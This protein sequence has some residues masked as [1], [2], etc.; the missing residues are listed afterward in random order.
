MTLQI[1]PLEWE[2][3]PELA[4]IH[5]QAFPKSRST[6]LGTLYVRKMFKWFIK[7]QPSLGY[8]AKQDNRIVGYVVGAIGGYGRKLFRFTLFEILIGLVIH[9]RLWTR[10]S[11]Y[12]LWTSYIKGLLPNQRNKKTDSDSNQGQPTSAALAGIGVHPEKRGLGVGKALVQEFEIAAKNLGTEKLTLSVSADNLQARRL[13]E[14]CGW[15]Q[16]NEDLK[17][18]SVHYSKRVVNVNDP[19]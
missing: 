12:S 11:T 17:T 6:Q 4:K 16:D 1:Q 9:P 13:Y 5:C 10:G 3:I 18:G 8:V 2:D 19:G 15:V 14:H 7:Y